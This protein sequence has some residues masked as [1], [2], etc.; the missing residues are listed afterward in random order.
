M[1]EKYI[2]FK[3]SLSNEVTTTKKELVLTLLV[4]FLGGI[5]LGIIFSPKRDCIIG[6]NNGNNSGNNTGN[7]N[8]ANAELDD[9]EVSPEVK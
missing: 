4:C 6:S 5:L 1:K 7:N 8:S 3:E 9:N 2:S